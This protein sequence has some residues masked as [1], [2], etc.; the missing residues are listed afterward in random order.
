MKRLIAEAPTIHYFDVN[1][2]TIIQ[3]DASSFVLRCTIMRNGFPISYASRVLT[4]TERN[5]AQIEK[6]TTWRYCSLL[7]KFD[8]YICGKADV[9]VETDHVFWFGVP[10]TQ[11]FEIWSPKGTPPLLERFL[12]FQPLK[13]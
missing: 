2:E 5:Y 13:P 8:Q 12:A 3:T 6:K 4:T 9:I 1:R 7:A 11:I 10:Y